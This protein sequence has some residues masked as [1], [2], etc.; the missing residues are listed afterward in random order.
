MIKYQYICTDELLSSCIANY[1]I[2]EFNQ[3]LCVDTFKVPPLG[4]PTIHFHYG[5]DTGFYYR[6]ELKHPS[7]II[8]QITRHLLLRPEPGTR[9]IG[10]DFIPYGMYNLLG[11]MMDEIADTAIPGEEFFDMKETEMLI[12]Q[13]KIDTCDKDRISSIERFLKKKAGKSEQRTNPVY[14]SIVDCIIEKN[15]L[16]ALE[17]LLDDKIKLRNLQRYFRKS[18]GISPKLFMQILRHKFVLQKKFTNP[19]FSW[20]DPEMDGYY[21]DQS[22]FDRDFIKFSRQRPAAYLKIDHLMA[23]ELV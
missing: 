19:S 22:H 2:I 14:D 20:K 3:E 8:G 23:R 17:S 9:F 4:F 7:L 5:D 6:D 16:I 21:Y 13:L 18:V 1:T 10:I 12:K 11:I 15:G